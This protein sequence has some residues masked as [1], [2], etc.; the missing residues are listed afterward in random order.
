MDICTF[1]EHHKDKELVSAAKVLKLFFFTH[2]ACQC[3]A[4]MLA[5]MLG[6]ITKNKVSAPSGYIG[7]E[8]KYYQDTVRPALT[9]PV[10]L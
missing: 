7:S 9:D 8:V 4:A 2:L 5:A 6:M 3:L 10:R 1:R